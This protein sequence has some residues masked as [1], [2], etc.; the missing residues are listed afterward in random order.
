M[1][2]VIIAEFPNIN[3]VDGEEA[4]QVV[5]ALTLDTVRMA[6]EWADKEAVVW[7]DDV[8]STSK[9]DIVSKVF[10]QIQQDMRDGDFLVI[11][12]LLSEIPLSNLEAY[13][14]KE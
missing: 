10:D 14:S 5:D 12:A 9:R 2:V 11:E 13:L 6:E 7:V 1:K 4:S 3:D 8:V